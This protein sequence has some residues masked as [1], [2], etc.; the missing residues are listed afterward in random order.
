M[1]YKVVLPQ[2]FLDNVKRLR[3]RYPLS[4][5]QHVTKA[6]S[7]L[8]L[9]PHFFLGLA[10]IAV[11]WSASWGH[12]GILGEYAFFP[13]WLGYILAV[14]ALV[15]ARQ[16]DSLL[17]A[18]P[19]HFVALFLLSAPVWWVFESGNNFTLN[20]HYLTA[21]EYS[22][23]HI[24]LEASIDFSTVIP[25]VFETTM[26]MQTFNFVRR[27]E[28]PHLRLNLSRSTLW[29]LMYIGAFMYIALI[30]LPQ[31]AF[32]FLWLWVFLLVDP[33]NWMR[34]RPSL[35]EQF[36]RGDLRMIGALSLAALVCGF[37]WEMWNFRSL[38]KWYYTVP[39]VGSLKIFEMPVL[40]YLGY[41]PFSWE[42]YALYHYVF[43]VLK[44]ERLEG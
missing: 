30:F 11:F 24:I 38:P 39:Y 33:L 26:L 4:A 31:F 3:K 23:P 42:L 36:S 6:P 44:V 25:A 21:R 1:S 7:A 28:F 20:W 17:T 27:L 5:A 10:L 9:K 13:Q 19:K 29:L 12:W 43:G 34:A 40:G 22:G 32:P 16:G 18:K 15:A 41:L 37:F 2:L 8:N 35:L 14:D